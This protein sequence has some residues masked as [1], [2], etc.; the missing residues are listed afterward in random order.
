MLP[1]I[2]I[3]DLSPTTFFFP[4]TQINVS[5]YVNIV[6]HTSHPH[7]MTDGTVYNVGMSITITGPRYSVVR[8]RP[9][10]VITGKTS[11][12]AIRTLAK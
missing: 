11:F 4:L 7:V 8:F 2:L 9:N 6:H 12:A 1:S 10:R 3:F 5:N